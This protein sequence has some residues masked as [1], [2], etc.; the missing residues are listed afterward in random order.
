LKF[1]FIFSDDSKSGTLQ[2][3]FLFFF[4][5]SDFLLNTHVNPLK[6]FDAHLLQSLLL[7]VFGKHSRNLSALCLGLIPKKVSAFPTEDFLLLQLYLRL[8]LNK[9]LFYRLVYE[10]NF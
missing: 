7:W 8:T 1:V 6:Q 4:E 9:R 10:S 2:F 5:L 3:L